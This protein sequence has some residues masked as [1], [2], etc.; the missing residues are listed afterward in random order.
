M[1]LA[2]FSHRETI[3]WGLVNQDSIIALDTL[4][5]TLAQ[6]LAQT[7]TEL[8]AAAEQNRQHALHANEV[9]WLPPAEP[10]SKILCVGLNYGRHALEGGRDLP[11]HP[12]LFLRHLDSFVGHEQNIIRPACSTQF[13]FEGELAVVIGQGG[14]HIPADKAMGHV[15]GYTCM[16]ENSVR[17]FQKHTAQVTAGKNFDRSGSL[18]P[19]IVTADQ[20]GAPE[21]MTLQTRLNGAVMQSAPV[22]DLIFSIPTLIAYISTFTTLRAGDII[23]TGTPEGIGLRRS[24][25]LFMK[26]GDVLEIDISG[27]GVLRSTVADETIS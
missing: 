26:A 14:R 12:S 19:W 17:D 27:L 9:Q 4:W 24:P 1:K 7:P 2:R 23:A 10:C 15:A 11:S 13:D 5:P 6:G 16:G 8:R 20:A 22:S 25:P 18:G 3:R 21:A